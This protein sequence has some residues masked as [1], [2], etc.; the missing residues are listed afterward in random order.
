MLMV[1]MSMTLQTH[2]ADQREGRDGQGPA[3]MSLSCT[4]TLLKCESTGI[5]MWQHCSDEK[6]C[7]AVFW[8]VRTETE[9]MFI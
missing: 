2:H 3:T 4:R 8:G 1:A 5:I 9:S 7:S 6:L